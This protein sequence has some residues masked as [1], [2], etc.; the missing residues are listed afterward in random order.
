M[1]VAREGRQVRPR[2]QVRA[3]D[4]EDAMVALRRARP[5]ATRRP[6]SDPWRQARPATVAVFG[7]GIAG[8]TAA[9]ELAER[10]F[11]VTVYEPMA[12]DASRPTATR[13]L[14]GAARRHGRHPVPDRAIGFGSFP[15]RSHGRSRRARSGRDGLPPANTGSASSPRTTCT[16][17]TCSSASPCMTTDGN[18]TITPRTVY[19]NVPARDHPGRDLGRRKA[20]LVL[21]VKRHG[22]SPS[23][24]ARSTRSR[25]FGFT[26]ADV[27]TFLGRIVRYLVTSPSVGSLELEDISAYEFFVGFDPDTAAARYQLQRC[28]RA[29]DP[30]H[31]EDPCRVR[32]PVRRR[33]NQPQH[34]RAAQ[35]GAR[36]LRQQGRRRALT[37]PRPKCWFDHWYPPPPPARRRVRAQMLGRFTFDEGTRSV[38][39]VAA[40]RQH[41]TR[42]NRCSTE[43]STGP[44]VRRESFFVA[45][46]LRR[47]DRG[48]RAEIAEAVPSGDPDDPEAAPTLH[49]TYARRARSSGSTDGPLRSRHPRTTSIP[50]ARSD[51]SGS[52]Y[53]F[54]EMEMRRWDRFRRW[55]VSNLLRYAV[56]SCAAM[57]T[58]RSPTGPYRRS[59]RRASG[60]THR[61]STDDGLC[62]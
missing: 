40:R 38:H 23:S 52:P 58:F 60:P 55:R 30:R 28:V 61:T 48:L 47:C 19:D 18:T 50:T 11:R 13:T 8:L 36:P 53:D 6:P 35:L 27:S 45:R 5:P 56:Q 14:G 24:W 9:H 26:P 3:E 31:A 43:Q 12:D 51:S 46:L 49:S 62:R 7:A 17:G 2:I 22:R 20:P 54:A 33:A 59:T 4:A 39:D 10:G 15:G 57:S 16:S 32:L 1:A 41:G 34:V 29:P 42:G 25:Q 44:R 21:P 37:G